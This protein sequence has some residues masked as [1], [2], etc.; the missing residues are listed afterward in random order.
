MAHFEID[1]KLLL[2]IVLCAEKDLIRADCPPNKW[3]S[4]VALLCQ[5]LVQ[6][7]LPDGSPMSVIAKTVSEVLDICLSKEASDDEIW[8]V[9][10]Q[11]SGFHNV[12]CLP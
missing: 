7:T 2:P 1:K 12:F 3:L 5:S 8:C 9:A 10:V 4:C 11:V 6:I